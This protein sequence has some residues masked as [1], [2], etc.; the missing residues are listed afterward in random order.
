[1]FYPTG[2]NTNTFSGNTAGVYG[3]DYSAY[4]YK[5]KLLSPLPKDLASG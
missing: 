5:M 1:M 4:P 2:L 3:N